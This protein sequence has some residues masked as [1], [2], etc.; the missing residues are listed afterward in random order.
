MD[1]KEIIS[2]IIILTTVIGGGAA[3]KNFHDFVRRAAL[4]KAAK[5]MPS[6][7]EMNK[8]LQAPARRK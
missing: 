5:G 7:V 4:E 6:L 8:R 3:L 1:M 2:A